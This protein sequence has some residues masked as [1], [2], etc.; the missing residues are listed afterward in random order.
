MYSIYLLFSFKGISK[1]AFLY[2]V[3]FAVQSESEIRFFCGRTYKKV[4]FFYVFFCL[5]VWLG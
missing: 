5:F 4:L 2:Y 1:R 3:F